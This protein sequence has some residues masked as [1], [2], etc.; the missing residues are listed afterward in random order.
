V[1]ARVLSAEEEGALA[2][3]GATSG[4]EPVAGG[5]LVCDVGGCSTQLVFGE[6]ADSIEWSTS[7]TSARSA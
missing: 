1:R 4:L 3:R 7:P 2:F 6:D 5:T